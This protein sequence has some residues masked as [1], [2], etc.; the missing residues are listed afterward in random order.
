MWFVQT[1]E[2]GKRAIPAPPPPLN[3]K[4]ER[5]RC[6]AWNALTRPG[7]LKLLQHLFWNKCFRAKI[8]FPRRSF[9]D[10]RLVVYNGLSGWGE[11]NFLL[12]IHLDNHT[13]WTQP[14]STLFATLTPW[15]A[16]FACTT[17]GGQWVERARGAGVC[18]A[19]RY[20]CGDHFWHSEWN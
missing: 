9:P 2:G 13:Q 7:P 18:L 12:F 20:T 17:D 8:T 4:C 16:R 11:T 14:L 19:A 3:G 6:D 10:P 1:Q 5:W 15:R